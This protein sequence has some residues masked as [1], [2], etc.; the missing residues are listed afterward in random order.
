MHPT[1][2]EPSILSKEPYITS[3][4]QYF[5]SNEPYI[6][7]NEPSKEPYIISYVSAMKRA[8]L[9]SK[10]IYHSCSRVLSIVLSAFTLSKQPYIYPK[11]ASIPSKESYL[12]STK[13]L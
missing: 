7:S 12:E 3:K 8:L 10:E 5:L 9:P 6:D 2:K 1:S 11:E 4:E 13:P